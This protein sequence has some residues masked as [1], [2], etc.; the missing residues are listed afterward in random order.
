M[1]VLFDCKYFQCELYI[2]EEMYVQVSIWTVSE[3]KK[4]E[5]T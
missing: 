5:N 4:K 1:K 2:T 3:L